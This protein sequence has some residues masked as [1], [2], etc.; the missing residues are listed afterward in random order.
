MKNKL[1]EK[2]TKKTKEKVAEAFTAKDVH[3]IK[4]VNLIDELDKMA[5]LISEN[6]REWHSTHFPELNSLVEDNETYLKLVLLGNRKN[7]TEKKIIEVYKNK[8]KAKKIESKA[9]DSMGAK[10]S[11]ETL[12]QIKGLA[13]KG[14]EIKKQRNELTKFI[15]KEMK[16]M[17]PNFSELAEPLISARM[18]SKAG[19]IKK[20]ALMPSSTIQLLGAE[21]ALFNHIKSGAKP[22]KYGFLFGHPMLKKVKRSEQGKFARTLAGKLTIAI[23]QDFFKGKKDV[24]EIKKELEKRVTELNK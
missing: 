19:S 22:P 12:K 15:E 23:R 10:L 13:E 6:T 2:L 8:E 5:N 16:E 14:I 1:K 3:V 17:L 20:L 4:A 9:K 7:F 24:T 11:E 18:L 21:K